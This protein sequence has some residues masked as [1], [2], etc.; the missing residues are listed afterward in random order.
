VSQLFSPITIGGQTLANRIVIAPM[1]Q[2]SAHNGEANNW[3]LKHLGQLSFSG[4]GLLILEATAVSPKGRISPGDLGLYSEQT[5][6]ALQHVIGSIR[7]DSDIRLAIQLGHAG[8]KAS[9]AV[10]WDGGA[11]LQPEAGGWITVAPSALPYAEGETPPSALDESGLQRIKSDF[12]AAAIRA[13]RIGF[14]AIEIHAAHGYLLHQFLSPLANQRQDDYGGTLEKR[15]AFPLEVFAAVHAAIPPGLALGIRISATD[16]IDGG[17]DLEQSIA[18]CKQLEALG[19]AYIH[20]SSGGLSN[21]QQITVGPGYQVPF[22]A[23]IRAAVKIPVIAV[24]LISEA[25]QAENIIS[26]GQADMVALGR[27]MLYNPRWPWHA[28]EKLGGQVKV[29]RQY[30]RCQPSGHHGLF[31]ETHIGQR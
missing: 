20:V 3:H 4:A 28:A 30:W 26:S 27:A 12:V 19:C 6:A 10:P 15:M 16:W 8:R 23:A 7:K 22:A 14:D 5:E 25:E 17:W 2:Y 31:G 9:S 18:F 21:Q 13:A 11:L 24:G 1:C 29:P